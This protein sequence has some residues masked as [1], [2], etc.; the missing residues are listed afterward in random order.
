MKKEYTCQYC[1]KF[2]NTRSGKW[3][4]EKKCKN[5]HDDE[6]YKDKYIEVLESIINPVLLKKIRLILFFLQTKISIFQL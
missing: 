3:K 2:Y 6:N 5:K 4:H 1:N